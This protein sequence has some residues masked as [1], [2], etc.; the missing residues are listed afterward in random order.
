MRYFLNFNAIYVITAL[1]IVLT[2]RNGTE[3]ISY[4]VQELIEDC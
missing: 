1:K 4:I 2:V 3:L